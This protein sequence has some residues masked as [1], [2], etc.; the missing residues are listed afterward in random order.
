[1]NAINL[2]PVKWL[3]S[4]RGKAI[5]FYGS[6]AG[7]F[8]KFNRQ[9]EYI[10]E[11][12]FCFISFWLSALISIR[13]FY[14]FSF[15]EKNHVWCWWRD[16]R[17]SIFI[18]TV[19]PFGMSCRCGR[20]LFLGNWICWRRIFRGVQIWW[21]WWTPKFHSNVQPNCLNDGH[22]DVVGNSNRFN[23]FNCCCRRR[24]CRCCSSA[25]VQSVSRRMERV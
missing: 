25:L 17:F 21:I 9:F 23:M 12:V 8:T 14:W 24:H 22:S 5:I 20:C 10:G 11:N 1:M 2:Q 13:C 3:E 4:E 6:T 7:R 19:S 18:D 16:F 15:L